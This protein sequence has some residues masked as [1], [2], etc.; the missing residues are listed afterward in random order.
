MGLDISPGRAQWSYGGFM[1]FRERLAALEPIPPL[2]EM[3]GYTEN[4][5][6]WETVERHTSLVPLL[7]HSDCDGYLDPWECEQMLP[8]LRQVYATWDDPGDPLGYDRER[9]GAL[10]KGMEHVMEHGCSM[11]FS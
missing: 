7:H 1:R 9:L 11:R 6:P 8:R 3:E 10:I 4:G 5:V 2:R